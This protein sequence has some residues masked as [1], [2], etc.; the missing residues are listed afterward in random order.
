MVVLFYIISARF[1]TYFLFF[2][3]LTK[4]LPEKYKNE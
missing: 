1:T 2:P 3:F 4:K